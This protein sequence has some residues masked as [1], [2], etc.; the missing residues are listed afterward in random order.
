MTAGFEGPGYTMEWAGAQRRVLA[1]DLTPQADLRH[2]VP[3]A[4]LYALGPLADLRGEVTVIGGIPYIATV[5]GETVRVERSFAHQACF[6]VQARVP[7]WSWVRIP[8]RLPAWPDLAP[9]LRDAVSVA[10]IDADAPVPFGITGRAVTGTLHVLDKR[11]G[12]PHTPARHE[13]AKIRFPLADEPVDIVGFSSA[14]HQGIFVPMDSTL[15][16]HVVAR[17]GRMAGHLDALHLAPGWR[18]ALPA[19]DTPEDR[20]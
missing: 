14:R 17:D 3:D 19:A 11:D 18:L 13:Q 12:Q 1:G 15:H 20:P 2:L 6:L 7:R 10:G 8:E 4:D 5:S 9:V 16:A